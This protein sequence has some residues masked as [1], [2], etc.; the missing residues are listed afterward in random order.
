MK[1]L[2]WELRHCADPTDRRAYKGGSSGNSSTAT[3]VSNSDR[4]SAFSDGVQLGDGSSAGSISVNVQQADAEVLKTLAGGIPD[5]VRAMTSAGADVIARAG[6][7]V[8]DMNRD[9]VA[10]NTKAFD[11]V[12]DFGSNAIDKIIN[13]SV[14]TAANGNA[15]AAAAVQ[16]FKPAENSN[17]DAL[18]WGLIAAAGIAAAVVLRGS[19]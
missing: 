16:S 12:V 13:A 5:A 10:A 9:S 15:L 18:K 17:A 11:H 2:R 14:Q 7:A 19:K 1:H 8:V 6:G 3:A 4:R